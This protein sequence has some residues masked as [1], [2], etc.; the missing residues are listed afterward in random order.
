MQKLL[1]ALLAVTLSY[2]VVSAQKP[3]KATSPAKQCVATTQKGTR[4]KLEVEKGSKYCPVHNPKVKKC[5][6][7]TK[8][9]KK[10]TR[11]A[12]KGSNYCWQHK[13]K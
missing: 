3:V 13:K 11:N 1:I 9:G 5:Q 7:K 10:C 8:S 4:C 2:T 6:G 12:Q